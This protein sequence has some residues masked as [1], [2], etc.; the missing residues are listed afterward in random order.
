[1]VVMVGDGRD[2]DRGR[3]LGEVTMK[4]A[5]VLEAENAVD[6]VSVNNLVVSNFNNLISRSRNPSDRQLHYK[7]LQSCRGV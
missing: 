5:C 2:R 3:E 1:M 7:I 6:K 4:V